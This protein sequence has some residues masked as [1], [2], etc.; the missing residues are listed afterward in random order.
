MANL[1]TLEISEAVGNR[2]LEKGVRAD[3]ELAIHGLQKCSHMEVSSGMVLKVLYSFPGGSEA[4][5]CSLCPTP[6]GGS[7]QVVELLVLWKSS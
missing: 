1:V 6:V 5:P 7:Q 2:P 4:G 3:V